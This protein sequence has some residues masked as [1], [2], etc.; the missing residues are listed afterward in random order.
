VIWEHS[1]GHI[2]LGYHLESHTADSGG[3]QRWVENDE[4]SL[5]S[6]EWQACTDRALQDHMHT[7]SLARSWSCMLHVK[8]P[9][10]V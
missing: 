6:L 4:N 10:I 7:S 9:H 2:S 8:Q 5:G 3:Q 1:G